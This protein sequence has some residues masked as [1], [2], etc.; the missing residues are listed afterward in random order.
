MK[1]VHRM[2]I[3][4]SKSISTYS[5]GSIMGRSVYSDNYKKVSPTK[6][7]IMGSKVYG[8]QLKKESVCQKVKSTL[9]SWNALQKR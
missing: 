4:M 2:A 7:S 3:I 9:G 8:N 5:S 1:F 6:S